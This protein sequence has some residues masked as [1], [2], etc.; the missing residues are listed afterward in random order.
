MSETFMG[1]MLT[2]VQLAALS[3]T[4]KRIH[5][6][7]GERLY[8]YRKFYVDIVGSDSMM[9][10]WRRNFDKDLQFLNRIQKVHLA[11][12][13]NT[14]T[15]K[16]QPVLEMM[17]K[18]LALFTKSTELLEFTFEVREM[19]HWVT[20]HNYVHFKLECLRIAAASEA[21][22]AG[23]SEKEKELDVAWAV[24]EFFKNEFR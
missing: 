12:T 18:V 2:L 21:L 4:C 6:E 22:E 23:K 1:Y 11:I 8:R 5:G 16:L 19:Y 20:R 3:R 17:G 24:F 15:T 14:G 10:L 9:A 7:V 13:I